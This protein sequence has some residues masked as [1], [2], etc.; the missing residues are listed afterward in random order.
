MGFLEAN[1]EA[2]SKLLC[3]TMCFK[4]QQY[5]CT[6]GNV[7]DHLKHLIYGAFCGSCKVSEGTAAHLYRSILG[8]FEHHDRHLNDWKWP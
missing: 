5:T 3:L 1:R 4:N 6:P 8:W 7:D 2:H